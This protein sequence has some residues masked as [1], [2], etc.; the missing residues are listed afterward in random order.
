MRLASFGMHAL[1]LQM[2][3]RAQWLKNGDLLARVVSTI[4]ED[5]NK[6][7]TRIDRGNIVLAGHSFGGSAISIAAAKGAPVRGLILLDPA[8]VSKALRDELSKIRVPVV[9]LGADRSVFKSRQRR[10]FY[11]LISGE[12][13]EVSIAGATH[14]DAQ[15]PSMFAL[16]GYGIDPFTSRDKQSLFAAAL[17]TSAFSL[18]ATGRIDF[19]W[20]AFEELMHAGMMKNPKRRTALNERR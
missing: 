8:V 12:M 17:T 18:T 19:A 14:D 1:V 13:A 7:D 6:L 5:E 2:V 3:N 4:H 20:E 15:Y 16:T 10:L 9:L 11:R